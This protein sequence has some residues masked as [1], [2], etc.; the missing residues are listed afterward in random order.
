M[1]IERGRGEMLAEPGKYCSS[2]GVGWHGLVNAIVAKLPEGTQVFQVKEKFGKLRFYYDLP[3]EYDSSTA[4]DDLYDK[5]DSVYKFVY[6]MEVASGYICEACGHA[7]ELRDDLG[8][9]LTLCDA[10]HLKKKGDKR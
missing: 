7:G 1:S 10:C 3:P 2:I 5:M 4:E 6:A 8:W 9:M